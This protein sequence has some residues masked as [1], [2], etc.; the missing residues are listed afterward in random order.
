MAG[1]RYLVTLAPAYSGEGRLTIGHSDGATLWEDTLTVNGQAV[2]GTLALL[3]TTRT[4]GGFLSRFFLAVAVAAA[5][6]AFLGI[7]AA[8]RHK[9]ALH[10]LVFGLVLGFGLLYCAVLPPYAAPD[11]K[12]HINQSFTLACRWANLFSEEDWRMGNVPI[13]T[14][15]RREHDQNALLQNENTTV[16]TWQ[17][18]TENLLTLS[19]DGVR[20][21]CGAGRIPDRP[22]PAAL[23]CQRGGGF[24][25][26]CAAARLCAHTAAG[27]ACKSAAVCGARGCGRALGAVRPAGAGCGPPCCQ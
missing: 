11:E 14:S 26:V 18:M 12:Y 17:E 4:I 1:R 10:K 22:Q 24:P 9:I 7:R 2:D 27:A 6:L 5:A 23:P 20:Q 8:L 19:P 3:I 15:Y 13:N 16:F 25:R 21:P